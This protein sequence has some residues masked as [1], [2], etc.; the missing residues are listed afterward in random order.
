[1]TQA[2]QRFHINFRDAGPRSITG[3]PIALTEVRQRGLGVSERDARLDTTP[4]RL[5]AALRGG[6]VIVD[7]AALWDDPGR[8][9]DAWSQRPRMIGVNGHNIL[10]S[11]HDEL[12]GNRKQT[13]RW[14]ARNTSWLG[15]DGPV[16]KNILRPIQLRG[17]ATITG[18]Q[19]SDDIAR[20]SAAVTR[21]SQLAAAAERRGMMSEETF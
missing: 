3:A 15:L 6:R 10:L 18:A 17:R 7:E 20:Y 14:V 4:L 21:A 8:A 2:F 11:P 19:L 13:V 5:T 12:R 16:A 1:M 9:G